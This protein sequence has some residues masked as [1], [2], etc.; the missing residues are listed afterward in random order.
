MTVETPATVSE[1]HSKSQ[2]KS[3]AG[4]DLKRI[5]ELDG[6]RGIAILL[7][8]I[9]HFVIIPGGLSVGNATLPAYLIALG[10]LT[11]SGVD[12]FFV[13]SG[14]LIGGILLDAR[15]SPSYFK[16]FYLRRAHRIVPIYLVMCLL[17]WAGI[18]LQ[19]GSRVPAL[20]T[21]FDGARP[22][23]Y[24]YATLTQNIWMAQTGNWGPVWLSV[25]WS[26]AIEEQFYLTL[27]FII[28]I[29]KPARLPVILLI[30][31]IAAPVLRLVLFATHPHAA[32]ATYVLTFCRAEGLMLGV[33]AALL[34]RSRGGPAWLVKHRR[35]LYQALGILTVGMLLMTLLE[36]RMGERLMGSLS[37]SWIAVFYLCVLLI[38]ITQR[39]SL[40]SRILR[41][42]PLMGLGSIAYGTYLFHSVVLV[43]AFGLIRGSQPLL[44]S[45]WDGVACLVALIVTLL[46]AKL[47]WNYFEKPLVRR[48][49]KYNYEPERPSP[50]AAN[51]FANAPDITGEALQ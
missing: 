15:N 3:Q 21:L 39:T 16:T 8:L 46:I 27:P 50:A 24:M 33:G 14:F 32:M 30:V 6:L 35:L 48:G 2:M 29:V 12:L 5:P 18:A 31:I 28:W 34:M 4:L 47:S 51:A 43:F 49:H 38:A 40:L 19:I 37:F 10:K 23:W 45:L 9:Y 26:L 36:R 1:R 13:L 25:T 41:I 7:V 11:W 42:R 17:L 44:G 20:T 22:P